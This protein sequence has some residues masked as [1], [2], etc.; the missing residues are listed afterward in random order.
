MAAPPRLLGHRGCR[1][2]P[3]VAE[4]TFAAFDLALRHGCDGFEFDVRRNGSGGAVVCHDSKIGNVLIARASTEQT[5]TLPLLEE[6]LRQYADRAFLDIELKVAGLEQ[7][8]LSALCEHP[9]QLGYL[10]SSFLPSV[11]IELSARSGRIPLGIICDKPSQRSSWMKLPVEY[12]VAEDG[13]VRPEL[14]KQVQD[15]GKKLLVWTVNDSAGM[16]RMRDWGVD[17]IISDDTELLVRTLAP[18]SSGLYPRGPQRT[19]KA[20]SQ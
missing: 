15:A 1:A 20:K 8:V 12:V 11:I 9:P 10:V 2:Y 4:N 14:V 17:G 19:E 5:Q 13:L 18:Q 6:V 7:A 3:K 16:L